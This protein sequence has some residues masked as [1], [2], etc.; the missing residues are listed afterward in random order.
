M[1]CSNKDVTNPKLYRC[2]YDFWMAKI[3]LTLQKAVASEVVTRSAKVSGR[4]Y[5]GTYTSNSFPDSVD[6][7]FD[8]SG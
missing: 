6:T 5:T 3:S 2:V 7:H 1:T 8:M 4:Q